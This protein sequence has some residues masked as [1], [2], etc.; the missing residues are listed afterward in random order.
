[1]GLGDLLRPEAILIAPP[2]EDKWELIRILVAAALGAAT[3]KPGD[4]SAIADVVL[5]RERQLSTGLEQGIALPHGMI[6]GDF[7]PC[8]AL[9][10]LPEGVEFECLDGQLAQFVALVIFPDHEEGKRVHVEMLGATIDLFTRPALRS[11]V[12]ECGEAAALLELLRE[13]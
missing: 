5:A 13:A 1:M 2:C 6:E 4:E 3:E 7:P 9:A 8:A 12:L 10:V 11:Q